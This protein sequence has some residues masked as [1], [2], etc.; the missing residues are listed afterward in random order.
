MCASGGGGRTSQ[1]GETLDSPPGAWHDYGSM[2]TNTFR[3]SGI[4]RAAAAA[5]ALALVPALAAAQTAPAKKTPAPA[6]ATRPDPAPA[7]EA[8]SSSSS[9]ALPYG[10][11]LAIGP[12]FE[13]GTALKLRLEGSMALRPLFP[14]S[15]FEL[16]L[17][18]ALAFW[19]QSGA[20]GFGYTYDASYVR[21]EIVPTA[22]I[23]APVAKDLGLY[24]DAGLGF[25]YYSASVT[26]TA[27][28]GFPFS[29]GA[30]GAGGIFKLA[31]GGYYALDPS[32]RLFIEPVG[33]NFY[34]G[35][36]NGFVYTI[37]FGAQ[38][39]FRG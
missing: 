26:T 11:S 39:R 35:D 27:P 24:G 15:T 21:F 3:F 37:M 10:L 4:V 1:A 19:G 17:P 16:A 32:W 36:G 22:R 7:P 14:N 23:S 9:S 5:L 28:V 6:A 31:G 13:G 33:L 34:F 30:S 29:V 18:L 12:S 38:Y 8:R 25:Q 20:L 2:T